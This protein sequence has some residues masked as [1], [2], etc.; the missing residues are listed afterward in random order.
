MSLRAYYRNP[1]GGDLSLPQDSGRPVSEQKLRALGCKWWLVEGSL[2]Q[3]MEK[4]KELS[5][6]LGFEDGDYEHFYDLSKQTGTPHDLAMIP[7]DVAQMWG[8]NNLL[9]FNVFVLYVASNA[10]LDLKEPGTNAFIRL[11]IPPKYALFCPGGTVFQA[12]GHEDA[13]LDVAVHVLF[14]ATD[15]ASVVTFGEEVDKHPTRVD[16]VQSVTGSTEA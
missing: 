13:L 14:R 1:T 11:V 16:Y 4:F 5:K 9:P 12:S 8:Q 2:D 10:Y 15:P 6:S 7:K 3:R